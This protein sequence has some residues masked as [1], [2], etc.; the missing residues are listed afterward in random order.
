MARGRVVVGGPLM[1][2]VGPLD[3]WLGRTGLSPGRVSR[4]VNAFAGLSSWMADRGLG[5][6]DL[7]EDVIDEH[8]HAERQRS[9]ARSPAAAQ[10]LPVVKKFL[11]SQGVLVL[12]PRAGRGLG[13]IPRLAAGP[14]SGVVSELVVWLRAQ[15]YA[16]GTALSVADTAARL[17]AWMSA[18]NIDV[19]GLDEPVLGRFVTAQT[20]GPDPH[21]SSARRI[22]TVRKFLLATGRLRS[23]DSPPP[24]LD[25]V[26]QCLQAWGREVARER[27]A[28]QGWIRE[29]ARWVRGFLDQMTGVD[30]QICWDRVDVGAVNTYI[31]TAGR[32]Y[33]L[34]SRRHLVVA[35]RS[36]LAW[37]F[38]A[39]LVPALMGAAVLAPAR[40][41]TALPQG[42]PAEQIEA[43]KAAA[44]RSVPLGRRNYAIAVIISRLGLRAG[45]VAGL[46]LDDIDWHR[47]QL[48]VT[49]K[50]GRI[51]CLPLPEDVGCTLVEH[52]RDPRPAGAGRSVFL[53]ARPPL[54]G[55]TRQRHLQCHRRAGRGTPAWGRYTL[56]GYGTRQQPRSWPAAGRWSRPVNCSVMPARTS[57]MMYARVDLAALREPGAPVGADP[58]MTTLRDHLAEYVS[59]APHVGLPARQA[60]VAGRAVLRL[61]DR[62]GQNDVYHRRRG[63]LGAAA[64]TRPTPCGGRC[65][66]ARCG[67]SPPTC[68]R[69]GST[70]R[71]H[72]AVLLPVRPGRSL[73]PYIYSQQDLNMLLEGC[74]QVFTARALSPPQC[75]PPSGLLAA[76][77]MRIGEAL[78]LRPVR[79]RHQ[80]RRGCY[81]P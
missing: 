77:G 45:E 80:R 42:L 31:A 32:G 75:K 74:P 78:R 81:Y 12:H 66:W 35:I 52:L 1:M 69:S 57:T 58:V 24:A 37:A 38:R 3:S 9:G 33:S 28:G 40:A 19:T 5:V 6:A 10:Y 47:G 62:R 44:D 14:L 23:A 79:H 25:A 59:D 51:L 50:G 60:G 18:E 76:T 8:I 27:G 20:S 49:G 21:P 17:G 22:V 71:S 2:W 16:P 39:R 34:S 4:T 73:I 30:D 72:P 29:Q 64:C 11:A 65:V 15:G 56:T 63:E 54:I 68:P 36:L 46:G 55:L 70:W 7:D 41:R 53:R 13:G 67:P 43:I 61:A 48:T 26:G